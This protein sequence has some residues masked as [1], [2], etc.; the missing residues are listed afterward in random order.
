MSCYRQGQNRLIICP[1][2]TVHFL[3][4]ILVLGKNIWLIP[5]CLIIGACVTLGQRTGI[6]DE[7]HIPPLA[8][9]VSSLG[10]SF[11]GTRCGG[12]G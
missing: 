3:V 4:N 9:V 5:L 2:R 7:R 6:T 11:A 8:S 10:V 12:G 1:F